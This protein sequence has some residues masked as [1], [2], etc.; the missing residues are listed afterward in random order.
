[1]KPV[2]LF[3]SYRSLSRWNPMEL[4]STGS[5]MSERSRSLYG[6]NLSRST[7]SLFVFSSLRFDIGLTK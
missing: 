3:A 5:V 2:Q 6:C 7:G 1:M 4:F